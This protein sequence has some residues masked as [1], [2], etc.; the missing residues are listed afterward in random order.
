MVFGGIHVYTNILRLWH[1]RM[2]LKGLLPLHTT[3]ATDATLSWQTCPLTI[4][5]FY[6]KVTKL[7]SGTCYPKS[8]CLSVVCNVRAPYSSGY[9]FQQC[10]YII[11]YPSHL[12]TLPQNFTDIVLRELTPIG[13]VKSKRVENIAIL[14][15]S[16]AISQKRCKIRPPIQII[17]CNSWPIE[18][19]TVEC[20]G[21]TLDPLGQPLVRVMAQQF[22]E[23]VYISEVDGVTKVKSNAQIA[24]NK[25]SDFFLRGGWETVPQHNFFPNF[26]NCPKRVEL[27][28]SYP[29]CSSRYDITR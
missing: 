18:N 8:V 11:L 2:Q 29:G 15:M 25:K 20:N 7:R 12:L 4:A 23:T 17:I 5:T 6:P 1:M 16:K 3:S 27:R 26:C 22:G 28:S 19:H 9:K 10:F 13:K 21:T 24:R 14:D